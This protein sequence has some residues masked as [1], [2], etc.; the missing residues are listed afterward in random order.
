MRYSASTVL[1]L[2][3]S[4]AVETWPGS[5]GKAT[6]LSSAMRWIRVSCGAS[7]RAALSPGNGPLPSRGYPVTNRLQ[8]TF[9]FATAVVMSA[10]GGGY[11]SPSRPSAIPSPTPAPAP[12]QASV[13][14]IY[15]GRFVPAP[16]PEFLWNGEDALYPFF[17]SGTLTLGERSGIACTITSL[18]VANRPS[19]N[20]YVRQAGG[21]YIPPGGV[22]RVGLSAFY[23]TPGETNPAR[24]ITVTATF[25]DARGN[26]FTATT[27]LQVGN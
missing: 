25:T 19:L 18:T 8:V 1:R 23:G 10:C 5:S 15:Q 20:D 24:L 13:T 4:T 22:V 6:D 16:T 17:V 2:R 9:L 11:G 26:Q 12:T 27:E 21:T 3:L 14:I 7:M